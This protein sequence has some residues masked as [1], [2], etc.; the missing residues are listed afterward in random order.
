VVS[1]RQ[2][3]V[4]PNPSPEWRKS[5]PYLIVLQ[6]DQLN[7]LNSTVVAPLAPLSKLETFERLTPEVTVLGKTLLIVTQELG[8]FPVQAAKQV[9][10]N[11][12]NERYRIIGALD[13]LFTGI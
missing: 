6:S 7:Q 1:L 12:E 10:T 8:A 13:L 4:F 3:D 9:V 11:L 2:F 5:R